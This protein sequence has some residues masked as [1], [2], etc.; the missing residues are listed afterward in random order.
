MYKKSLGIFF[1]FLFSSTLCSEKVPPKVVCIFVV[2]Q[3]AYAHLPK[4]K[5]YLR[6]GLK[7]LFDN[8]VEFKNAHYAHAMPST[9]PGHT[10]LNTGVQPKD[11]GIVGN[12]WHD[13]DNKQYPCTM[14]TSADAGEYKPDGKFSNRGKSACNIMVDGISDQAIMSAY[15]HNNQVFAISLK[16]RAAICMAGHSGKAVWYDNVNNRFTTS[17]A[18]FETFPS[19]LEEFNKTVCARRPQNNFWTP[20]FAE[21]SR[22]Y[23]F[24]NANNYDYSMHKQ[25][26][27]KTVIPT[28][29]RDYL[30]MPQSQKLVLDCA[31]ECFNKNNTYSRKG[32]L[33]LWISFSN[34]DKLGH[35]FGPECQETADLLYHLDKDLQE[36]MNF[37]ESKVPASS[38]LYALTGDHGA[39]PIPELNKERTKFPARRI[40]IPKM[41]LELNKLLEKKIGLKNII[42]AYKSPHFFLDNHQWNNF[43]KHEKQKITKVVKEYLFTMPGIRAVWNEDELLTRPFDK[44]SV[45]SFFRNQYFPGRSG[46]ITV[47]VEPYTLFSNY[48]FGSAHET[49]YGYDTHVPLVLYQKGSLERAKIEAKVWMQQ[50]ANTIADLVG[51]ARPS[52]SFYPPLPL[53]G[54][55]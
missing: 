8:G 9:G 52:A 41:V 22:A 51:I 6:F 34:L 29:H 13:Q 25:P 2:D 32:T 3:F 33:I 1:S 17:K 18:Y 20:A 40:L 26:L 10:T 45:E 39:A 43:A 35:E 31:Q 30:K 19:W 38:I 36:F 24:K 55:S 7:K 14:D 50:F 47:M 12:Y 53:P 11:H 4:I 44:D 15:A 16:A 21:S 27:I 42:N 49:P 37:I 54:H 46:Q 5:P 48:T 28:A 23:H